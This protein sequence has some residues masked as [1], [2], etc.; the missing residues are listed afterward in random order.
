MGK[1]KIGIH[2]HVFSSKLTEQ[3]L[4]ILDY[5]REIGFN[6]MDINLRN[7]DFSLLPH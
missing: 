4:S 1:V 6:S 7:T 3:N 2:Q 5:V